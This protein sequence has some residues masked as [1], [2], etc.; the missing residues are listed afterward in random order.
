VKESWSPAV[1]APVRRVAL[2]HRDVAQMM[3]D[4]KLFQFEGV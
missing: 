1:E 3:V 4:A 2:L